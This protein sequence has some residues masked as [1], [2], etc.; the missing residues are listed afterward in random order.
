[1]DS[2]RAILIVCV[3]VFTAAAAL[4]D[5]RTRKLPNRITVPAFFAALVFHV[6]RGAISGGWGGHGAGLLHA[7]A[8]FATGF[9]ILLVLWLSGQGGGGDVKFMGALGAWLGAEQTLIV[10]LLSALLIL[11]GSI[12]FLAIHVCASGLGRM[13]RRCVSP[14][15]HDATAGQGNGS[16][17]GEYHAS[18]SRR[19]LPFG[20][21]VAL[22]TWGLLAFAVLE[23]LW[24]QS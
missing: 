14:L 2:A 7:L 19:L 24:A 21:P 20:V 15:S 23:V 11:I 22:A 16:G 12:G 4:C 9:G 5:L 8:G 1:M 13:R 17:Y 10:F 3:V 18:A 6:V